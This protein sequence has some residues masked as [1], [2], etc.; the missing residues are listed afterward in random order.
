MNTINKNLQNISKVPVT[1]SVGFAALVVALLPGLGELLQYDRAA[2]AGGEVWRLASC[3]LVHWSADHLCWDWLMFVVLGAVCEMRNPWRMRSCLVAGIAAVSAVVYW[4]FP[5][6][7][8]YR[9]L[10]GLDS[11]LFTL[12]ATDLFNE[13]RRE[14]DK[15]WLFLTG[16]LLA[17]FGAKT[18]YEAITG[19]AFF[20]DQQAAKF[21]TLVF[22]HVAGAVV[23]V[24]ISLVSVDLVCKS[25]LRVGIEISEKNVRVVQTLP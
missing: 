2:I 25:G 4:G 14:G 24:V 20:V 13:A 7:E 15:L 16:G 19:Q 1:A 10:S 22:D 18:I 21:V 12:L 9:G 5:A 23:G 11:A 3:Y 17:A 8:V 6:I